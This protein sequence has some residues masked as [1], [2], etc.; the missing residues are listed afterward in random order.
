MEVYRTIISRSDLSVIFAD[1]L[2]HVSICSSNTRDALNDLGAKKK[3]GVTDDDFYQELDREHGQ[4]MP[5]VYQVHV[6]SK[7]GKSQIKTKNFFNNTIF[8]LNCN[9]TLSKLMNAK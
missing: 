4:F 7:Q 6:S 8:K 5:Q 3:I 2:G 9:M 1:S